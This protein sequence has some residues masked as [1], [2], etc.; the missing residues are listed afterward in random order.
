[1]WLLPGLDVCGDLGTSAPWW[2]V[3][4]WCDHYGVD[5]E[6]LWPVLRRAGAMLDE[7]TAKLRKQKRASPARRNPDPRN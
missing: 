1:M 7:H 3:R 4:E 2:R 5:L 6:W